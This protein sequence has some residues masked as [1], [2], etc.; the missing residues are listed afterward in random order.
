MIGRPKIRSICSSISI[1]GI[2]SVGIS[3]RTDAKRQYS[4]P[5]S[6]K[7]SGVTRGAKAVVMAVIDTDN[8]TLPFESDDIKFEILPPGHEATSNIPMAIIG[9]ING[10]STMAKRQVMAGNIIH[11]RSIP[12]ITDLGF[13]NTSLKVWNLIPKATP[14]ITI[15]KI[16]FT[17]TISPAPRLMLSV[18]RFANCS[19]II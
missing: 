8:S 2:S 6:Q 5:H 19:F 14:N 13:L 10:L 18:S 7:F 4:V 16:M 17:T 15:A 3:L 11:C 12:T 1:N 9:V